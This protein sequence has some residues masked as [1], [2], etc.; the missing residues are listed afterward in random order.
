[1]SEVVVSGNEGGS[2]WAHHGNVGRV[3]DVRTTS[4]RRTLKTWTT[5]KFYSGLDKRLLGVFFIFELR[6]DSE[7]L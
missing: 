2:L 3:R 7:S 4:R 1:M 6:P 5:W